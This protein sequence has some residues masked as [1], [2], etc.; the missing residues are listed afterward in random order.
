MLKIYQ[1]IPHKLSG[2]SEEHYSVSVTKQPEIY[3]QWRYAATDVIIYFF[4]SFAACNR[5]TV[6][7]NLNLDAKYSKYIYNDAE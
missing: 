3:W 1:R 2:K 7:S 4:N 5:N 6:S